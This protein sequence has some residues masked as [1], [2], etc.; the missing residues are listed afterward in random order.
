MNSKCF[1]YKGGC[2][3]H[4][5]TLIEVCKRRAGLGYIDKRLWVS[6]NETWLKI[7]IPLRN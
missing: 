5:H 7:V 2:G 6:S 1:S 4:K 3:M